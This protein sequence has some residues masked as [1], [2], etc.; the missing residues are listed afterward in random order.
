MNNDKK[1]SKIDN[2]KENKETGNKW[3]Y[4]QVIYRIQ[5]KKEQKFFNF[6]LEFNFW[7]FLWIFTKQFNFLS[8][9]LES[10]FPSF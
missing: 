7:M 8:F 1:K 4:G 6:S 3:W 5:I 10:S 2:N 9:L